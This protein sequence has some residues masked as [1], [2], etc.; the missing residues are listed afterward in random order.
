MQQFVGDA[1]HELRTPLTV[2]KGYNELLTNPTINDEQRA[3]AVERVRREVDRMDVAGRRPPTL[4]RSARGAAAP[5]SARRA[6]C[7]RQRAH[8]TSSSSDHPERVVTHDIEPGI[9]RS[10]ARGLRSID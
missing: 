4:G 7:P 6:Q 8:S 10:G 2:I 5:R 9:A 3:R 1:S